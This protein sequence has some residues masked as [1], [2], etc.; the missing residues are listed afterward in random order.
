MYHEVAEENQI[1]QIARKIGSSWITQKSEFIKQ[2]DY[3]SRNGYT[4]LT[5]DELIDVITC[6]LD[7]NSVPSKPVVITFDDGFAGNYEYGFPILQE[8]GMTATFFI[9]VN[10]IGK[11][12]MLTWDQIREMRK[13]NMAIQSHTLSHPL[14][15]CLGYDETKREILESRLIIQDKV[16]EK[17]DFISLPNGDFN[18]HYFNIVKENAFRGGCSSIYGFNGEKTDP[19]LLRRID[20]RKNLEVTLFGDLLNNKSFNSKWMLYRSSLKRSLSKIVSK[21]IYHKMYK[22]YNRT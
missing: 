22:I 12:L 15:S 5:L 3:L 13:F 9:T 4:S 18:R 19:F 6:K 21:K 16:G 17:V 20:I 1:D 10:E 14:L 8:Y 2:I 11:K 7:M